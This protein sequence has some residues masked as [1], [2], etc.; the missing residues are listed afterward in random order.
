MEEVIVQ[1][2]GAA[3]VSECP[4]APDTAELHPRVVGLPTAP[5]PME[6]LIAPMATR[7]QGS[8]QSAATILA[9][10]ASV[11]V[12]TIEV[13][14]RKAWVL[15]CTTAAED[16]LAG[17]RDL[18]IEAVRASDI[19]AD[20]GDLHYHGLVHK[21]VVRAAPHAP[22]VLLVHEAQ[23]VALP[24]VFVAGEPMAAADTSRCE[25]KSQV[26]VLEEGLV[27]AAAGGAA[28]VTDGPHPAVGE[29]LLRSSVARKHGP[30]DLALA[31]PGAARFAAV[32]VARGPGTL[33][34]AR[35]RLS[36]R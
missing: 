34:P 24:A 18:D 30:V 2:R 26:L 12:V 29:H 27:A 15:C 5:E 14:R 33:D 36:T 1:R 6:P 25:A 7:L 13:A 20:V 23:L 22:I 10:A 31:W 17:T 21:A 19:L 4:W 16:A 8:R 9:V 11:A 28:A 32:P 35:V 3:D